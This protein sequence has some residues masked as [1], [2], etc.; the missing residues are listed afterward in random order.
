MAG[1]CA[2]AF[3]GGRD[4]VVIPRP[5]P[6][7]PPP[8]P[9]PTV[10]VLALANP[11]QM[12]EKLVAADLKSVTIQAKS[13]GPYMPV[14]SAAAVVGREART[15]LPA[16]TLLLAPEL[17]TSPLPAKG[18]TLVGLL[19]SAGEAPTGGALD[20]GDP[21]GVV[22]VPAS[23]QPPYPAPKPLVAATVWS[24][25]EGQSAQ[26]Y[27]TL[28][29]PSKAAERVAAYALHDEV[30]V[31]RLGPGERFPPPTATST[32]A[33]TTPPPT[34]TRPPT[35]KPTRKGSGGTKHAGGGAGAGHSGHTAP[36]T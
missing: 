36:R 2:G 25:V 13:P 17:A 28:L 21:V 34:T 9:P 1:L 29:V 8:A 11:V 6:P 19:L 23:S 10:H 27:V 31:I 7:P 15:A 12:G 26:W 33:T 30:A 22:F 4:T 5:T 3:F 18:Q 14:T 35:T 20:P 32:P 24:V 16:G